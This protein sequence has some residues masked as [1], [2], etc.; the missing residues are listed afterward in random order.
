MCG[1]EEG[2]RGRK[3]REWVDE[4]AA[5]AARVQTTFGASNFAQ[6]IKFSSALVCASAHAAHDDVTY[7]CTVAVGEV[8]AL[9]LLACTFVQSLLVERAPCFLGLD[10]VVLTERTCPRHARLEKH[11]VPVAFPIVRLVRKLWVWASCNRSSRKVVA[12]VAENRGRAR[13]VRATSNARCARGRVV[14]EPCGANAHG[15]RG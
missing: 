9:P 2:G 6:R 15:C 13:S 11:A 14:P 5:C 10:L 4:R 1:G 12:I 7:A 8:A 3:E